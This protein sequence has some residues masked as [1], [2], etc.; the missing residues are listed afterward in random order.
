MGLPLGD[1]FRS[2]VILNKIAEKFEKRIASLK[3]QY[4]SSGGRLLIVVNSV[5]DCITHHMLPFLIPSY[6]L[7]Q[8]DKIRRK[9]LF[10]GGGG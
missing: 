1:K 4:L 2:K 5:L 9:F 3:M 6:V 8:L 10:G 7:K